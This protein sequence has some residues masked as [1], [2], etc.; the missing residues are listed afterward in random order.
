MRLHSLA[1]SSYYLRGLY[2][3]LKMRYHLGV[4]YTRFLRRITIQLLVPYEVRKEP[5]YTHHYDTRHLVKTS[6][7]S[8][9]YHIPGR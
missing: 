8:I 1:K 6:T 5:C 7:V 3:L 4:S 2:I 9:F